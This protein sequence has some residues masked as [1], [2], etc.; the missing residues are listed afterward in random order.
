[1]AFA[2]RGRGRAG[3]TA[4]ISAAGQQQE[5][6]VTLEP[7]YQSISILYLSYFYDPYSYYFFDYF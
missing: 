7:G 1:V 5:L 6:G 3:D 4:S 2:G